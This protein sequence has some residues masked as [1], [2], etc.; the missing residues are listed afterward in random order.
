MNNFHAYLAM[1]NICLCD[2]L[3]IGWKVTPP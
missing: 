1:V 2:S 3:T